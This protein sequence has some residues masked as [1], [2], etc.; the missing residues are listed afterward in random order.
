[1]KLQ[2]YLAPQPANWELLTVISLSIYLNTYVC[3]NPF[4]E[5][6]RKE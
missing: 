4:P 1:M 6:L 2:S 3:K 5:L